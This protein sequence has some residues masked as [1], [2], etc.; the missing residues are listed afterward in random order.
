MKKTIKERFFSFVKKTKSCWEWTGSLSHGYGHMSFEGAPRDAHRISY[1]LFNGPIPS[2]AFICHS[3]DNRKCVN[4][5]HL[6]SGSAKDNVNDAIQKNRMLR[7]DSNG[8]HKLALR[9]VL[10]IRKCSSSDSFSTKQF[11]EKYHVSP[12]T[13]Q[14]IVSGR[15]WAW[16]S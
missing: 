5:K 2:G 10:K 14:S 9:Q 15:R 13:I 7:G 6:W 1:E 4:P 16:I 12:S 8:R 3:C 11:S